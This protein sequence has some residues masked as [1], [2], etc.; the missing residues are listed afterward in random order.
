LC[1]VFGF[2]IVVVN[3]SCIHTIDMLVAIGLKS[4]NLYFNIIISVFYEKSKYALK[5]G[6][7]DLNL[8][9]TIC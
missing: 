7:S 9:T 3:N 6:D 4:N 2:G 5:Y 1:E 8:M